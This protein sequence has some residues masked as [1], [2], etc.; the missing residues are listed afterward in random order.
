M[1]ESR[2][3][4]D[5]KVA[6]PAKK[7]TKSARGSRASMV[8]SLSG[9]GT[10]GR[11]GRRNISAEARSF[12]TFFGDT[13][14]GDLL[15]VGSIR[16]LSQEKLAELAAYFKTDNE[17]ALGLLLQTEFLL[18]LQEDLLKVKGMTGGAQQQA[19]P[20]PK[21]GTL[22]NLYKVIGYTLGF[23]KAQQVVGN[24]Q[25]VVQ[26]AG[27][28]VVTKES[29]S[30]AISAIRSTTSTPAEEEKALKQMSSKIIEYT[31]K[32]L[33]SNVSSYL[34][35]GPT[36]VSVYAGIAGLFELPAFTLSGLG[37]TLSTMFAFPA[38]AGVTTGLSWLL[39]INAVSNLC[40][41][42]IKNIQ[43]ELP[44][45]WNE[46]IGT[47][48]ASKVKSLYNNLKIY[49]T[50][51]KDQNKWVVTVI[52]TLAKILISSSIEEKQVKSVVNAVKRDMIEAAYRQRARELR[53]NLG[54][55]T[56][57]PRLTASAVPAERF[58]GLSSANLE[59][60]VIA[61]FQTAVAQTAYAKAQEE[62][63]QK[64]LDS[65]EAELAPII[66]IEDAGGDLTE[67]QQKRYGELVGRRTYL[68]EGYNPREL[69]R[70]A[71]SAAGKILTGRTKYSQAMSKAQAE[72]NAKN[73]KKL[74]A[75]K[76]L[77]ASRQG[78]AMTLR[79]LA[80]ARLAGI[81]EELIPGGSK[82]VLVS[83]KRKTR[84]N[85]KY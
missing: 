33:V 59:R 60:N 38:T 34:L 7:A 78:K 24:A 46:G 2:M 19:A 67:E 75:Y 9:R 47:Y 57:L 64:E 68:E 52:H 18:E 36:I 65:I 51:F 12:Y 48:S 13:I 43:T 26:Q 73:A 80:G 23:S 85:R 82:A 56:N 14:E 11:F 55:R 76:K 84:K 54:T 8:W 21:P 79:R 6:K 72:K 83:K 45:A 49:D 71:G 39:A 15:T 74:E 66:A 32:V 30:A 1:A 41:M 81:S 29:A 16:D 44:K 35:D 42:A 3:Q 63:L 58:V 17:T 28:A 62:E 27:T 61:G 22:D 77:R 69:S 53:A 5:S 4:S 70:V 37:G 25:A 50:F 40:W 10:P 20:A 31:V